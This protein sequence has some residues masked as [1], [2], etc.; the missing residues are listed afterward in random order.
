MLERNLREPEV[1]LVFAQNLE[2]RGNFV[3]FLANNYLVSVYN[4]GSL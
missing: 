1:P 3:E 4:F 2:T